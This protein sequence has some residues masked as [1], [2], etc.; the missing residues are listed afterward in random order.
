MCFNCNVF[1]VL[2]HLA[3]VICLL[4]L[5]KGYWAMGTGEKQNAWIL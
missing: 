3:T 1:I 2:Y 4:N 5:R